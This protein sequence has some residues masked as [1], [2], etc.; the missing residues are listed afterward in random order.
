MRDFLANCMSS[1]RR[2]VITGMGVVSPVGNDLQTFWSNITNGVSGVGPVTHFD[3]SAYDCKIAAEVRDFDPVKFFRVPK[4][5]RRADR[6]TQLAVAAAKL[7]MADAGFTLPVPVPERFGC[8]IGSGIGG[9]ATIEAQHTI[10]MQK[11]PGRLSPFLIP[12]LIS[13]MASG[14]VSMEWGLQGPNYATTSACATSAHSLGEAWRML[15]EG[16]ADVFVAG[17]SE[18]AIVP[19]GIGGFAAMKAL[20]TRNDEPTKASRPWDRDRDGFVMGEGAGVVVMEE[21]EMARKRGATIYG[22]IAGYGL[23]AD[24]YHMSAPLPEG[25]GAAR[26]MAMALRKAG[27]N[28]T[29]VD[30]VNAHGTSTP[31]GDVCETKALKRLFGEHATKLQISSSKSMTG[32]LLGAAGVVETIVCIKALQTGVI[33]PTINLDNPG[34]GC[35]LDYVPHTAREAKLRVAIN[36]SFGFGGHNAT[37]VLKKFEG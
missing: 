14:T 23:S 28:P 34:E 30:Y 4:D 10:L 24:A 7:A 8:M 2:V 9:L 3:V 16:D 15:R 27:L 13:N 31:V 37:L 6:Y 36:N 17:G 18:S 29:D 12:M 19:M 20:S 33:P 25:E 32:H 21:L 26:C 1:Q 35:D 11:G 5:V 22:E